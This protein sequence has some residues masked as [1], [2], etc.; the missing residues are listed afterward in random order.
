MIIQR[1]E[2]DKYDRLERIKLIN[3]ICGTRSTHLIGTKSDD[4]AC[5]VAIFSSVTHLGSSPPLILFV[6]RPSGTT[7]RDTIN[8]I[9]K[10]KYYTIN[11][12]EENIIHNAHQT[13]GKYSSQKSEF[14]ECNIE[15][16][17]INGFPAP[18]VT[19]SNIK[20]GLRFLE[21][22]TVKHNKTE[23]VIGEI[24]LIKLKYKNLEKNFKKTTSIIGLNSYYKHEKIKDLPYV[25]LK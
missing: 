14:Q 6:S 13:S 18:F 16:E 17:Y 15:K 22:I 20:I 12:V 10:T 1:G 3:S 2:I 24:L 5:N 21:S 11:S 9:K 19:N 7:K 4:N 23:L 25:K 8:N